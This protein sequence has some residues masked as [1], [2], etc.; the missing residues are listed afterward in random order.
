MN[1]CEICE[2]LE[3]SNEEGLCEECFNEEIKFWSNI[4]K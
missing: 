4:K 1:E 2:K 3:V